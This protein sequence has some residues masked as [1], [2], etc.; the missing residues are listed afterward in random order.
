MPPGGRR[1]AHWDQRVGAGGLEGS[2]VN[3]VIMGPPGAGK[4]TQAARLADR[5]GFLHL[6]PGDL[7]RQAVKEGSESG[8]KAKTYMDSGQLVPDGVVIALIDGAVNQV[9]AGRGVILDGFPRTLPQAEALGR[10]LGGLGRPLDVV[11]NVVL[12]EGE[13]VRRLTGRRVCRKC[14]ANYHLV[15]QPPKTPRVCDLCGGELYQR[16]DD[17]EET[18]R[19]RFE[20]YH[21]ETEPLIDY[22]GSRGLVSDVDGRGDVD[23]V[24][25]RLERALG[26][27]R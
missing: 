15:F 2:A 6:S 25:V 5:Y 10:M 14:G 9:S 13:A 18:A 4:G 12:T 27:G 8:L 19:T 3:L 7:L 22:Y 1:R 17:S 24:T 11:V 26:L 16:S 23:E 21:Q 20:F